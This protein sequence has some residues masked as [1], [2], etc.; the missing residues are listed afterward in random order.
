MRYSKNK[1]GFEHFCQHSIRWHRNLGEK[2][3]E[4]CVFIP[5]DQGG[6][7]QFQSKQNIKARK[8]SKQQSVPIV[9]RLNTEIRILKNRYL[10]CLGL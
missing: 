10:Q 5:N 6:R 9:G 3:V 4:K 2:C 7:N 8:V 1:R